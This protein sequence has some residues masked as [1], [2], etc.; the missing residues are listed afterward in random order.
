V[1]TNI[2][3]LSCADISVSDSQ[4]LLVIDALSDAADNQEADPRFATGVTDRGPS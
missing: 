3:S 4:S 1:R 2:P